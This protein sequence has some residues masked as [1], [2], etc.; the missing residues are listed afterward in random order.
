MSASAPFPR[1]ARGAFAPPHAYPDQHK[2]GDSC[3]QVRPAPR[4]VDQSRIGGALRVGGATHRRSPFPH[5]ADRGRSSIPFARAAARTGGVALTPRGG[6][7]FPSNTAALSDCASLRVMPR[8]EREPVSD[9]GFS[10]QR[11][12]PAVSR[13]GGRRLAASL[14]H[15]ASSHSSRMLGAGLTAGVFFSSQ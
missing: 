7:A 2:Q 15:P 5:A 13:A 8:G 6:A 1:P 9:P 10:A 3:G 14:S 4:I 11:L 12:R